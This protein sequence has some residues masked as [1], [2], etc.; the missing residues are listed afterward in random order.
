M[1]SHRS[2]PC[3]H[4]A[5][6]LALGLA[7]GACAGAGVAPGPDAPL[8]ATPVAPARPL[9]SGDGAHVELPL[10]D[11]PGVAFR[12][13]FYTG[14]IDDPPGKEGL[15]SLT[16]RVMAEGG[17]RG[18]SY[19]ELLAELYPMATR[20]EVHVGKEQT[21]FSGYVH[22][23]HAARFARLI[24]DVITVPRLP[25]DAIAR[26][27]AE[28]IAELEDR[29]RA[30]DDEGLGKALLEATLYGG[31]PGQQAPHPYAHP[32]IGTSAGL[33]A[34]TREDVVAHR[35]RVFGRRRMLIGLAGKLDDPLRRAIDEAL[36]PLAPGEARRAELPTPPP[37]PR[38]RVV[39][40]EKPGRA[41]A[42]SMGQTIGAT[43]SSPEA[44]ALGLVQ[45]WFG[46]HRQFHG[47]LMAKMRGERGLNYGDYAY[48]EA[49][50]QEGWS[51][52]ART[53]VAR[54]QQHFEIWIRPVDPADAVFAIRIALA[55]RERLVRQGPPAEEVKAI[56]EFLVGYSRL[57]E[58]TPMRK[59]GHALD[60][61]FY[62][63]PDRLAGL[64]RAWPALGAAEIKTAI[65][66]HLPLAPLAIAI[67]APDAEA[68]KA[69]LVS[70]AP[71]PKTY[72]AKVPEAVTAED[73]IYASFPLGLRAEDV[74][75]LPAGA[76]FAGTS[77]ASAAP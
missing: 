38:S 66:R 7:L 75:I 71:S 14:S 63:T 39:I 68:L 47:V 51:R 60:D 20:V 23:D 8:V 53:N 42:I 67:V 55:E 34:I 10:A 58:V 30:T 13:L 5:L 4:S 29:L 17:T 15:T 54:R 24:G 21:V 49:F 36:R 37:L 22:P 26:V 11:A 48:V 1:P 50:E 69:R 27:R 74:L 76:L 46:E 33:R 25:D 19:S 28:L 77:T 73:A 9:P 35:A 3:A 72:E 45:S 18:L 41:V 32:S 44:A 6:G 62:G 64:R 2:A 12:I 65:V 56:A 52:N 70:G 16:A 43:R 40:A 61:H 59:L 57:W 31:L